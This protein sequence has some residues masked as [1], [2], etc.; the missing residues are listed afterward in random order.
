MGQ[1]QQS[2]TGVRD[3]YLAEFG[4]YVELATMEAGA[5]HTKKQEGE[6]A[7]RDLSTREHP[8]VLSEGFSGPGV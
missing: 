6:A 2:V 1:R 5:G 3:F 8:G 4:L 7:A